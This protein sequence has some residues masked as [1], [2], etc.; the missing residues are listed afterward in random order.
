MF[1]GIA[2]QRNGNLSITTPQLLR[3]TRL[4]L[5]TLPWRS[6]SDWRGMQRLNM[7]KQSKLGCYIFF[8]RL[9]QAPHLANIRGVARGLMDRAL[10]QQ[11]GGPRFESR[12][13]IDFWASQIK[14]LFYQ[15]ANF[16]LFANKKTV[17]TD[18]QQREGGTW[19]LSKNI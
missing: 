1:L 15:F 16:S 4:E 8:N 6:L 11:P 18:S 2:I 3:L 13:I 9:R 10:S 17:I 7:P 14:R 19:A 12:L 5:R